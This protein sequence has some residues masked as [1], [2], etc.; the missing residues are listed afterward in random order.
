MDSTEPIRNL[1]KPGSVYDNGGE[2]VTIPK[3]PYVNSVTGSIGN[4]RGL[5]DG[6]IDPGNIDRHQQLHT[7]TKRSTSALGSIDSTIPD[8]RSI[9]SSSTFTNI[10][11]LD[12]QYISDINP[13]KIVIWSYIINSTEN[14]LTPPDQIVETKA[15]SYKDLFN[16]KFK[17]NYSSYADYINSTIGYDKKSSDITIGGVTIPGRYHEPSITI[18]NSIPEGKK[19]DQYCLPNKYLDIIN[20]INVIYYMEPIYPCLGPFKTAN[21]QPTY[22]GLK[23]VNV[24]APDELH[25]LYRN[26]GYFD[27][28]FY[29]CKYYVNGSMNNIGADGV[30]STDEYMKQSYIIRSIQIQNNTPFKLFRIEAPV[31]RLFVEYTYIEATPGIDEE[32]PFGKP[33]HLP[34]SPAYYNAQVK[35]EYTRPSKPPTIYPNYYHTFNDLSRVD[36]AY[37]QPYSTATV[38]ITDNPYDAYTESAQDIY[39][40]IGG[41]TGTTIEDQIK[42]Y[43]EDNYKDSRPYNVKI[44]QYVYYDIP[45]NWANC[46]C[47]VT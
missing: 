32:G 45:T 24:F 5:A 47:I 6:Q 44:N 4:T 2:P 10:T 39:Y 35:C 41:Y 18:R 23:V 8:V 46:K 19:T 31:E 13:N 28:R 25:F 37:I 26:D 33:I 27:S 22:N 3:G 15:V 11:P 30:T 1:I 9:S 38:N 7:Y 43:I 34:G 21:I 29:Y 17:N 40:Y 12:I 16:T 42:K 36:R 14:R 20:H